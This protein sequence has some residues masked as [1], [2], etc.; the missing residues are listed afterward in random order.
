[1]GQLINQEAVNH[2]ANHAAWKQG[3]IGALNALTTVVAARMIVLVAVLGGI[4]LAWLA[5]QAPDP[6]KLGALAI[7]ALFVLVP[8]VWLA[9]R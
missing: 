3:L 1:M 6:Y 4:G 8:T 5:L 9:G 2:A 7:Y